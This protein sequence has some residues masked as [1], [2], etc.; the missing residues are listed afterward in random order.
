ML[1]DSPARW[2]KGRIRRYST[3]ENATEIFTRVFEAAKV[4]P[5][6]GQERQQTL[7]AR[8]A[9]VIPRLTSWGLIILA[10]VS[11]AYR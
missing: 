10:A 5:I 11:P 6:G 8:L 9:S 3:W 1:M 2:A 7:S 4:I